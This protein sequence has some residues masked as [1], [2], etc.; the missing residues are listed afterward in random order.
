MVII[1]KMRAI[2]PQ[3]HGKDEVL[4]TIC[5]PHDVFNWCKN[6]EVLTVQSIIDMHSLHELIGERPKVPDHAA[7]LTEYRL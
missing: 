2:S 5:V 4:L 6:F 1:K 3:Y 7:F